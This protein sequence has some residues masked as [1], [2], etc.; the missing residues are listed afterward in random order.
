[1]S[2]EAETSAHILDRPL[3]EGDA[4]IVIARD[5]D[6]KLA[7]IGVGDVEPNDVTPE[8]QHQCLTVL[9]LMMIL[10]DDELMEKLRDRA[11]LRFAKASTN[12][13]YH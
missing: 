11:S 5:G 4:A 1:M 3:E 12:G 6:W 9:S 10:E 13:L 7:F 8:M 2:I